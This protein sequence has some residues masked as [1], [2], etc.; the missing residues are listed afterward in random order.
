MKLSP[1]DFKHLNGFYSRKDAR[2]TV[3]RLYKGVCQGCGKPIDSAK[4][5]H[6]GHIV[7][8]THPEEFE[9]RYPGLDV[10]NL[11]NLHLL[12]SRCNIRQSNVFLASE[13]RL[14]QMH[15]LAAKAIVTRLSKALEVLPSQVTV[16][17]RAQKI[18][19]EFDK[20]P[21]GPVANTGATE[22]RATS[23]TSLSPAHKWVQRQLQ[24]LLDYRDEVATQS[25]QPALFCDIS[26]REDLRGIRP[27]EWAQEAAP[28]F[29]KKSLGA[30]IGLL[31]SIGPQGQTSLTPGPG[32]PWSKELYDSAIFL[33]EQA[34]LLEFGGALLVPRKQLLTVLDNCLE[35]VLYIYDETNGKM[36]TVASPVGTHFAQFPYFPG[37]D[38][39]SS[40]VICEGPDGTSAPLTNQALQLPSEL[41]QSGLFRPAIGP[42][43]SY[44]DWTKVPSLAGTSIWYKGEELRQDDQRVFLKLLKIASRERGGTSQSFS[45][46]SFASG[47][48]GWADNGDSASK[49]RLS[50]NRLTTASVRIE[51]A[52]QSSKIE[53]KA[54]SSTLLHCFQL[55]TAATFTDRGF[56]VTLDPR[57]YPLFEMPQTALA[58]STRFSLGDGLTS[59]IWA[60]IQSANC[61]YPHYLSSL[62]ELAYKTNYESKA[63]TQQ[64]KGSL[65]ELMKEGLI[66][67]YEIVF[68]KGRAGR[69][70]LG[71]VIRR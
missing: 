36:V 53:K 6:V 59:W 54:E 17:T 35:F 23:A 65:N 3:F 10:D 5:F 69:S 62:R 57:V 13:F 42:R 61:D 43:A 22:P 51:R 33:S 32:A 24:N 44:A 37:L 7:P 21:Y 8:Q 29:A 49:L 20:R 55:L 40:R 67:G 70:G 1:A 28:L 2:E 9:K 26:A 50:L 68:L 66:R 15:T 71:L 63:F 48:L 52:L 27:L 16:T 45:L 56:A 18:L 4:E 31:I 12:H 25:L 64:L 39:I 11:L 30:P 47:V 38:R 58:L 34:K 46:R 60:Y 14:S 41:L 19:S